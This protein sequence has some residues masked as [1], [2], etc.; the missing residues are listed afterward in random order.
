MRGRERGTGVMRQLSG[1]ATTGGAGDP[2]TRRYD[3]N[4]SP[5]CQPLRQAVS[6][7][8]FVDVNRLLVAAA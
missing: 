3:P 7:G 6:A 8:P 4:P 1:I 2:K 5:P